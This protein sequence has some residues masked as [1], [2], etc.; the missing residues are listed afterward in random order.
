MVIWPCHTFIE[1][2]AI[3]DNGKMYDNGKGG[4]GVTGTL[5]V[6]KGNTVEWRRPSIG[7]VVSIRCHVYGTF[8]C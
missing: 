1:I 5:R 6:E 3:L 8:L 4:S 7:E 2:K